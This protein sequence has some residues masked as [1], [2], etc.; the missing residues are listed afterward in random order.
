MKLEAT[1][2][3]MVLNELAESSSRDEASET[4]K[5]EV[6]VRADL[7]SKIFSEMRLTSDV[8]TFSAPL[9]FADGPSSFVLQRESFTQRLHLIYLTF[10]DREKPV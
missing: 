9:T 6:C 4:G 10:P 8:S 2:L 3:V 1:D 7:E 5:A